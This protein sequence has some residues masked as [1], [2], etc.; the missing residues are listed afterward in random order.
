MFEFL[1][2]L[3]H[4]FLYRLRNKPEAVCIKE[5][6][7]FC[8]IF[9]KYLRFWN[10]H[11]EFS[12]MARP[13]IRKIC[14]GRTLFCSYGKPRQGLMTDWKTEY[15][16]KSYMFRNDLYYVYFTIKFHNFPYYKMFIE[17]KN[18]EFKILLLLKEVKILWNDSLV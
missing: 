7:L 16:S 18:V 14:S 11:V 8:N 10:K 1:L 4:W 3:L 17:G 2:Y 6:I 15:T 9:C 12:N 13:T 5:R